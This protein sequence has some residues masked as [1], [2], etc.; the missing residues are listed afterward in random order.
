VPTDLPALV[1]H[2]LLLVRHEL[3]RN[4]V[5]VDMEHEKDLPPVLL[6]PAKFEQVLVNLVINAIHAMRGTPDPKLDILIYSDVLKEAPRD[7]GSRCASRLRSGDEVMIFELKDN[8]TGIPPEALS[9][10]FDP[11][12]TTKP[13]GQGTGLGLCVVRKII[14]LHGG[15]VTIENRLDRGAKVRIILKAPR[16]E[17]GSV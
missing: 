5:A 7:E 16:S 2:V 9:K 11:F 6:D 17:S 14:E 15:T 12:F 8:G 10:V 4:N 1:E 13:T 3:T